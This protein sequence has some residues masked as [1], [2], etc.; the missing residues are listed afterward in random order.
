MEKNGQPLTQITLP[1]GKESQAATEQEAR[2][3]HNTVWTF[4]GTNKYF[5][6]AG[7]WTMFPQMSS[8]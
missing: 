5:V 6:P 2:W 8:L 1:L 3:D 4:L 7:K